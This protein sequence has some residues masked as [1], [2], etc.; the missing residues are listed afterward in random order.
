MPLYRKCSG[1]YYLW[2]LFLLTKQLLLFK[3]SFPWIYFLDIH[4]WKFGMFKVLNGVPHFLA[5]SLK[6]T[7]HPS[8]QFLHPKPIF[9]FWRTKV[10]EK[11]VQEMTYFSALFLVLWKERIILCSIFSTACYFQCFQ[12]VSQFLV[13]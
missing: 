12:Y 8:K 2:F 3:W 11:W 7:F 1:K 6:A 4:C 5:T 13:L 9:F 10:L